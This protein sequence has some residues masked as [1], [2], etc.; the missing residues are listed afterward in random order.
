MN[1][2]I[3][4]LVFMCSFN[5][6]AA[7]SI[8]VA[9]I[10]TGLDFKYVNQVKLCPTGHKDFTGEGLS[11][12]NGHGSNVTGLIV[13]NNENVNYCVIILKAYAF[14][15]IQKAYITEALTYAYNLG[16]N[17]INLS[18]GGFDEIPEEKEIVLK[19][20][21]KNIILVTSSGNDRLNLDI[22]CVYYP[23]CYDKRIYVIGNL[24]LSSNYGQIVDIKYNGVNQTAFGRTLSGSSQAT[25][26]FTG[27]LIRTIG[28]LS[29]NK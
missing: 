23:A 9:I 28:K 17:I 3:C 14:K 4:F 2:L 1:K 18:G 12:I 8:K 7:N 25:A 22:S 6:L 16:V 29:K 15:N 24:G 26:L 27:D 19:L 20:L 11:D 13:K 21:N 5:I 10:D